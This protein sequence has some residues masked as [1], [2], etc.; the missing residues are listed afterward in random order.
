MEQG[1]LAI[2]LCDAVLRGGAETLEVALEALADEDDSAEA[3]AAVWAA[4]GALLE[5]PARVQPEL[6]VDL[7]E[8]ALESVSAAALLR[9]LSLA[10]RSG[11]PLGAG[12]QRPVFAF[13]VDAE[14]H[15]RKGP[16]IMGLLDFVAWQQS[17]FGPGQADQAAVAAALAARAVWGDV[18]PNSVAALAQ[19]LEQRAAELGGYPDVVQLLLQEDCHPC[20]LRAVLAH[21]ACAQR[22]VWLLDLLTAIER[23]APPQLEALLCCGRPAVNPSQLW[24]GGGEDDLEYEYYSCP[25]IAALQVHNAMQ[26]LLLLLLHELCPTCDSADGAAPLAQTSTAAGRRA[27][28]LEPQCTCSLPLFPHRGAAEVPRLHPHHLPQRGAGPCTAG[29]AGA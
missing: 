20:L 15:T 11:I 9:V 10:R 2:Q 26:V 7:L 13:C 4:A 21:P 29:R 1:A 23:A 8:A 19:S 24:P 27:G 28:E 3:G 16:T 12:V 6:V 22:G 18:N 25:L 17:V 5:H 14:A